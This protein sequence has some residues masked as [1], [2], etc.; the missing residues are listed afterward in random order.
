MYDY[1]ITCMVHFQLKDTHHSCEARRPRGTLK[2]EQK[3]E[4]NKKRKNTTQNVNTQNIKM[5]Y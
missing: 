1:S 3:N 4:I 2:E 5:I